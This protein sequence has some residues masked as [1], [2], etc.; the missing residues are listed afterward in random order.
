MLTMQVALRGS[1]RRWAPSLPSQ[2]ARSLSLVEFE[3]SFRI[4]EASFRAT[5]LNSNNASAGCV[6]RFLSTS[7]QRRSNDRTNH[8]TSFQNRGKQNRISARQVHELMDESRGFLKIYKTMDAS[9]RASKLQQLLVSWGPVVKFLNDDPAQ[10]RQAVKYADSLANIFLDMTEEATN[11][12]SSSRSRAGASTFVNPAIH[13]WAKIQ[14]IDSHSDAALRAEHLLKRL[15]TAFETTGDYFFKPRLHTF[16]G[17]LDA[18]SKSASKEAP[19]RAR[20]WL[21]QMITTKQ[22][23]SPDQISYNSALNA[24]ASRGDARRATALFEEMKHQTKRGL[25]PDTY[26]YNMLMKAWQ[27][28]GSPK[29]PEATVQLLQDFKESY[30]RQGKQNLFLRPNTSIYSIPMSLVNA[31]KAHHLLDEMLEW[32]KREPQSGMQPKTWHYAMVMNAYAK[33]GKPEHSE[34][35]FMRML[36]LN[37]EGHNHV[38]PN[39]Q[40][41]CILIK[42]WCKQRTPES[43]KRAEAI[44]EQMEE[45]FVHVEGVPSGEPMN[46]Y[47]YNSGTLMF[48]IVCVRFTEPFCCLLSHFVKQS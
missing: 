38:Q 11:A 4:E 19:D 48:S 2:I 10:L 32:H 16:N 8:R 9:H 27:R 31:E 26:S 12:D 25:Q 28:S 43:L 23:V 1:R 18:F 29:A 7:P 13:G 21:Q 44:L 46:T 40:N 39:L 34:E 20:E 35:I 14:R 36:Q 37:R 47:G 30:E 22:C 15:L 6:V 3:S 41:F 24:Y 17:V 42:A 33:E 5:E 45:L